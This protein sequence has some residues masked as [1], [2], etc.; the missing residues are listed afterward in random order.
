MKVKLKANEKISSMNNY[1]GLNMDNWTALNQGKEV[2][3][4]EIPKLIKDQGDIVKTNSK[5]KGEK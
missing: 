2:E 5:D 4:D 1:R 3:L